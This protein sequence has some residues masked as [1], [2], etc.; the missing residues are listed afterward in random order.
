MVQ[1]MATTFP[2][3]IDLVEEITAA[4]PDVSRRRMFGCDAY[5]AGDRIF[6]LLWKTGRIGLK[7]P[8][9]TA[10]AELA[11]IPGS[12]PWSI[13]EKTMSTWTLVPESWHDEPELLHP[14]LRRAYSLANGPTAKPAAKASK[15][16]AKATKP[17]NKP[18]AKNP[19]KSA[20]ARGA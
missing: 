7:L 4:L 20:A 3:L 17:A 13:G 19:R 10:H 11:A 16:A 9:P 1:P 2:F 12:E 5:F 15:P 18:A 14:W 6:V 8:D